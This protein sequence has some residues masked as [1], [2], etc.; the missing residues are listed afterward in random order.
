MDKIEMLTLTDENKSEFTSKLEKALYDRFGEKGYD[1]YGNLT[2]WSLLNLIK[3]NVI[4]TYQLLYVN[5]NFWTG[6]GGIIRDFNGEKVY[7]AGFR[8]F[9]YAFDRH[10]GLGVK[11]YN[12]IYNTSYQIE[13]A[14]FHKCSKVILSFNDHNY[15]LFQVNIKYLLP[16]AFP[17]YNFVPSDE[18]VL[19]NGVAQWLLTL[20]LL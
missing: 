16:R 12:H 5:D 19:F 3:D 2:P 9:S 18:P 14:K 7:Q 8:T 15:Q 11:P 10:R 4:D 1:N 13:R 20:D 17:D 6:S